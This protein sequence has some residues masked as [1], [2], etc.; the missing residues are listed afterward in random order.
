LTFSEG[1]ATCNQPRARTGRAVL[2]VVTATTKTADKMNVLMKPVQRICLANANLYGLRKQ[3][4][5]EGLA[6]VN[7]AISTRHKVHRQCAAKS[8]CGG[9]WISAEEGLSSKDKFH[10]ETLLLALAQLNPAVGD[11]AGN[12]TKLRAARDA[13]LSTVLTS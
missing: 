6:A 7:Q 8:K 5:A 4:S 10:A 2:S 11:I 9:R 1:Q 12:V 13:A 3:R